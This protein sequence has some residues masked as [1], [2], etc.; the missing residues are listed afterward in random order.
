M[1][2]VLPPT[3][4][5]STYQKESTHPNTCWNKHPEIELYKI[6]YIYIYIILEQNIYKCP[7]MSKRWAKHPIQLL[8]AGVHID[9]NAHN[10]TL[11]APVEG[12]STR[13]DTAHLATWA[14]FGFNFC[15]ND[16]MDEMD[17]FLIYMI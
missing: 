2:E 6:L 11:Q 1:H 15:D 10:D 16:E 17:P 5:T 12:Y 13:Q 3:A 14:K 4:S 7:N 9:A 8:F